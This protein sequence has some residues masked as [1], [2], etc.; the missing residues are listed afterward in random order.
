MGQRFRFCRRLNATICRIQ[1]ITALLAVTRWLHYNNVN[2]FRYLGYSLTCPLMQAELVLLIAPAVPC[3]K[4]NVIVI[5]LVTHIMMLFGWYTSTL[6]GALWTTDWQ[7]VILDQNFHNLT[8]KG[9]LIFPAV[10]VVTFLSAVQIPYIALWYNCYRDRNNMPEGFNKMLLL[11]GVTW[12]G[13]PIWWFLSFEGASIISD[14]KLNGFGFMMLNVIS[15]GG[16]TF[17]MIG[18]VKRFKKKMAA[19]KPDPEAGSD[20]AKLSSRVSLPALPGDAEE[21]DEELIERKQEK[22][23]TNQSLMW[24]LDAVREFDNDP[25]GR[26]EDKGPM[27]PPMPSGNQ[28]APSGTETAQSLMW[29]INAVQKFDNKEQLKAKLNQGGGL[30]LAPVK[31]DRGEVTSATELTNEELVGELLR[32]MNMSQEQRSQ[33]MADKQIIARVL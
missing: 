5:M 22:H 15:K 20:V 27:P 28:A 21:P 14:T 19:A 9:W 32:R 31:S 4:L 26:E 16:F 10:V 17:C 13:F 3:Y 1:S 12:L 18:M 33:F 23:E 2:G 11:T 24:M 25:L 30:G 29:M 7:D 6:E 8:Y